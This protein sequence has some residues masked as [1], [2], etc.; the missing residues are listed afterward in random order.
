MS[1]RADE[2]KQ[3]QN[4]R[5]AYKQIKSELTKHEQL[6]RIRSQMYGFT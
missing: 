5:E 2:A 3:S 1:K 6:R 4:K